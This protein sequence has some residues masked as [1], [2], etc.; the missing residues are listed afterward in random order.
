MG[1][2]NKA[3]LTTDEI[4]EYD[5]AIKV[6]PANPEPRK[7]KVR[8]EAKYL[9]SGKIINPSGDESERLYHVW[10]YLNAPKPMQGIRSLEEV[11]FSPYLRI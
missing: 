11:R 2:R 10:E 8:W 7:P 4:V 5:E 3:R 6:D 1:L 9:G